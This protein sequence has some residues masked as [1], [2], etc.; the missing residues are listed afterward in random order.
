LDMSLG[1][2]DLWLGHLD[3]SEGPGFGRDGRDA[4]YIVELYEQR[5]VMVPAY[6]KLILL[7]PAPE[8]VD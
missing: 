5:L 4:D 7:V 8:K 3:W 1:I 2:F 6:G